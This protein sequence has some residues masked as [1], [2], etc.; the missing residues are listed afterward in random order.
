MN[1]LASVVIPTYKGHDKILRAVNS[2]QNQSIADFEIIVVNNNVEDGLKTK[3]D[4]FNKF[5]KIK[6]N[7][8]KYT[9]GGAYGARTAGIHYSKGDIVIHFDDD[10][11]FADNIVEL[12]L[13]FL[14]NNKN[15]VVVGGPCRL[16]F[17]Y[18]QPDWIKNYLDGKK[19][20][21]IWGHYEPHDKI[22]IGES[23]NLWGG[24]FAIRRSV[25]Y[26]AGWHPDIFNR[27]LLGDG[28]S[29]LFTDIANKKGA[30]MAFIPK[31]YIYH[32]MS[33]N[34]LTIKHVRWSA[35]YLMNT[36][37]YRRY[38][39]RHPSFKNI[40][41]DTFHTFI[42]YY[43]LWIKDFLYARYR[44]DVNSINNQYL[45]SMGYWKLRYLSWLLFRKDVKSFIK[46]KEYITFNE[47]L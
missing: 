24:N 25:Y 28:D 26:W 22:V 3:I 47:K 2:L 7:Y 19:V 45:A 6:V 9:K 40:I 42:E 34:R 10:E 17:D 41:S 23:V 27:M 1:I 15:V 18:E 44:K 35:S 43:K 8:Y 31:A 46:R 14:H 36:R 33:K 32:H 11:T 16:L 39:N 12:Y 38:Q 21:H 13:D 4:E 30:L 20:D 5:S 37:M 29:G